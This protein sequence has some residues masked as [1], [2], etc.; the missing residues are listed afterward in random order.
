MFH[1]LLDRKNTNAS[2][3]SLFMKTTLTILTVAALVG[4]SASAA[5]ISGKVKLTGTPPPAKQITTDPACGKERP[6]G[7]STRFYVVGKDNGLG[8]V[9]VYVKEG[10]K[11]TPATGAA[12]TLDQVAC[13][14]T[15][16]IVGVQTGQPLAVKNSDPFMHNVHAIPKVNGNKER[17]VAQIVKGQTNPFTFDKP[18]VFVQFKCDVHPWMF[19]Y[20]GVCDHPYFAVTDKDGNFKISGL[21]AGEYTVEAIHR[22]AGSTTQKI[23][24]TADDKKTAEFTLNVPAAQ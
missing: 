6:G 13:E 21:P 22:K 2:F 17:N 7:I 14:Y 19:A 5:E 4:S 20:V 12:P 18:E 9:F 1:K 10:A 8:D 24:V 23:K 3:A 11:P 15:P 16:Y